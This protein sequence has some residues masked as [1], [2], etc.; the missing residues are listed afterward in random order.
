M[1]FIVFIFTTGMFFLV[2][3]AGAGIL[4]PIFLFTLSWVVSTALLLAGPVEYVSVLGVVPGVILIGGV[5]SFVVGGLAARRR[6]KIVGGR[7]ID[8]ELAD[9]IGPTRL[10]CLIGVIAIVY[11]CD[12]FL[13]W[14]SSGLFVALGDSGI[15]SQLREQHWDSLMKGQKGVRELTRT[16]GRAAGIFITVSMPGYMRADVT[17]RRRF[18]LLCGLVAGTGILLDSLGVAGRFIPAFVALATVYAAVIGLER[19]RGFPIKLRYIFAKV[20]TK[21]GA[22]TVIG[23]AI[24]AYGLLVWFPVARNPYLLDNFDLYLYHVSGGSIS[25]NLEWIAELFGEKLVYVSAYSSSYFSSP[26]VYFNLFYERGDIANWYELGAYNFPILSKAGDII[27][28]QTIGWVDIRERLADVSAGWGMGAN[29][30]ATGIR[31]FIIDFGNAGTMVA[32]FAY[33]YLAQSAYRSALRTS[34]TDVNC[35]TSMVS[36]T[37]IVFAYLSAFCIGPIGNTLAFALFLLAARKFWAH[38]GYR[39]RYRLKRMT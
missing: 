36:V 38:L 27:T 22:L 13:E 34:R 26:I 28:G 24:V 4:E 16:V 11:A 1:L 2:I 35:I 33:G 31:D 5:A 21:Y 18:L 32:L 8:T 10:D 3:R 23:L 19:S 29:P 37:C 25:P 15:Y 17:G 12:I 20:R 9:S 30:W 6:R 7:L 39:A 14:L